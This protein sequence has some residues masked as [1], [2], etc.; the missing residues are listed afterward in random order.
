MGAGPLFVIT[1]VILKAMRI[2]LLHWVGFYFTSEKPDVCGR[3]RAACGPGRLGAVTG[4]P[5][6]PSLSPRK[7]VLMWY[8]R[9][10]GR[11][12]GGHL[13]RRACSALVAKGEELVLLRCWHVERRGGERD[14]WA[15]LWGPYCSAIRGAL[16]KRGIP[17]GSVPLFHCGWQ[18]RVRA[19]QQQDRERSR[20]LGR[21]GQRMGWGTHSTHVF[22]WV[23]LARSSSS[24]PLPTPK[25]CPPWWSWSRPPSLQGLR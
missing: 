19:I 11:H 18:V 15:P 22:S 4:P 9:Q 3:V 12:L 2:F 7:Q 24:L 8:R 25:P 10:H 17:T 14:S 23:L 13:P 16:G 6:V 5:C 21:R 1:T 20:Q